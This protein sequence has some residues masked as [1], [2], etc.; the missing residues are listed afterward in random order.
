MVEGRSSGTT[1][2]GIKLSELKKVAIL[3]PIRNIEENF[4]NK[5]IAIAKMNETK[6]SQNQKLN[7]FKTFLLSDLTK[8]EN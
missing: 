5:T 7:D 3:I 2:F 8:L 4:T 1:V 6:S